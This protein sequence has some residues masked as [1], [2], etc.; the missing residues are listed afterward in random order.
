M[1]FATPS[2]MLPPRMF[3]AL[4]PLIAA[5]ACAD[6]KPKHARSVSDHPAEYWS[7]KKCQEAFEH[8]D[9]EYIDPVTLETLDGKPPAKLPKA[10]GAKADFKRRYAY[11]QA[12]SFAVLEDSKVDLEVMVE[13][14]VEAARDCPELMWQVLFPEFQTKVAGDAR[15]RI[16]DALLVGYEKLPRDEWRTVRV[17]TI[18]E[19]IASLRPLGADDDFDWPQGDTAEALRLE[20]EAIKLR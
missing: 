8:I 10:P 9:A 15:K 6:S 19:R 12:Y 17:P 7:A 4:L 2:V 18:A 1:R 16:V 20:V 14:K 13:T 3:V 5:S 11:A